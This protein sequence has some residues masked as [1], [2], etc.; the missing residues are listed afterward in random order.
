MNTLIIISIAFVALVFGYFFGK[1]TQQKLSNA[2]ILALKNEIDAIKNVTTQQKLFFETN[3]Q[4]KQ[5]Q[6]FIYICST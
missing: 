4:E 3:L 1:N 2:E 6:F 5:H